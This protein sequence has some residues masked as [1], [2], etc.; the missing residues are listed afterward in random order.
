MTGL[1]CPAAY[2]LKISSS[3]LRSSA[4]RPFM[5]PRFTPITEMLRRISTSGWNRGVCEG[6]QPA[7]Q[8]ALSLRT[9]SGRETV[10]YQPPGRPK[11]ITT[12]GKRFAANGVHR[13]LNAVGR[14]ASH[15]LLEIVPGIIDRM[16]DADPPQEIL[17]GRSGRAE[18]LKRPRATQ[19]HCPNADA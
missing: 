17:F 11:T 9:G 1:T 18:T 3:W 16:V 10:H 2:I 8:A 5:R 6:L 19:L 7:P 4:S 14:D 13:H 15:G 12:L